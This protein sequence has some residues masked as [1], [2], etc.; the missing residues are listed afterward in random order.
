MLVVNLM[1][2]ICDGWPIKQEYQK[3]VKF[4]FEDKTRSRCRLSLKCVDL[5]N[6]LRSELKARNLRAINFCS[7]IKINLHNWNF[8]KMDFIHMPLSP[9]KFISP[10]RIYFDEDAQLTHFEVAKEKNFRFMI[11]P[12]PHM[13]RRLQARGAFLDFRIYLWQDARPCLELN[14]QLAYTG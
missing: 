10:E 2:I 12:L 11:K 6:T 5:M 1:I 8:H 13:A 9:I 3:A 4:R 7:I 14:H